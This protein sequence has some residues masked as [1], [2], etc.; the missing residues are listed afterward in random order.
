MVGAVE[1]HGPLEG[2]PGKPDPIRLQLGDSEVIVN[3]RGFGDQA[4]RLRELDEGH[5][6]LTSVEGG[7][8]TLVEAGTAPGTAAE[9]AGGENDRS[10]PMRHMLRMAHWRTPRVA[11]IELVIIG[12]RIRP[13]NMRPS[14]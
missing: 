5:L 14:V 13:R 12:V 2:L 4:S 6:D 8:P 1:F 9:Q 11:G 3:L 7:R 10:E